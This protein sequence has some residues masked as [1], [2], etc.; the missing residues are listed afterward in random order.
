[1][2]IKILDRNEKL[3]KMVEVVSL[4]ETFEI[5]A[6]RYINITVK[7]LP[8]NFTDG[9]YIYTLLPPNTNWVDCDKWRVEK[10]RSVHSGGKLLYE[11]YAEHIFCELIDESKEIYQV[12]DS[13]ATNAITQALWGTSWAPG[14][15]DVEGK[16]D[17]TIGEQ[18]SV[19]EILNRISKRWW[20][21]LYFRNDRKV[22][23]RPLIGSDNNLWFRYDK[24]I[25]DIDVEYDG[26]DVITRLYPYGRDG[27]TIESVNNGYKYLDSERI[28]DYPRPKIGELK[29][30]RENAQ[31]LKEFALNYLAEVEIPKVTYSLD[32]ADLSILTK[33]AAEKF[34]MGD[35]I[36]VYDKE[37]NLN[38]KTRIKK[39]ARDY[40]H[41]EDSQTEVGNIVKSLTD[42]LLE[43]QEELSEFV[44]RVNIARLMVFNYLLNSRADDGFAYWQNDGWEI[45]NTVGFSGSSSFRAMGELGVSKIL[46]Q[47]IY[48]AHRE[49]YVLSL[50]AQ[51]E[52]IEKGELAK[53][54][55]DIIIGYEDETEETFFLSLV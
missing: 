30:E 29:T 50:R 21:E 45:D 16:H 8:E 2:I 55:I 44:E 5:S 39:I 12:L 15:I 49:N 48:P 28:N 22:D 11:I 1:M 6:A 43:Q 24:N 42:F 36:T 14:T 41:P 20:G 51:T 46:S 23:F 10:H 34:A 35:I 54:G 3:I 47:T 53:V 32:I 18:K 19:L 31:N 33:Y 40:C 38:I 37:L 52:N 25:K 7:E 9:W 26:Q 17:L 13:T 27:L 4:V